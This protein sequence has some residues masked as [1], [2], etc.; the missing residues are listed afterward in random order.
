MI[1]ANHRLFA[2]GVIRR[3][4]TQPSFDPFVQRNRRPD[5]SVSRLGNRLILRVIL[6][7]RGVVGLYRMRFSEPFIR[8][9]SLPSNKV[10]F[11]DNVSR[12]AN[13]RNINH[14]SLKRYGS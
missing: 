9:V 11:L 8:Q 7:Y 10:S 4:I 5:Q 13:E 1:I 3:S 14:F 12:I 6:L 2:T